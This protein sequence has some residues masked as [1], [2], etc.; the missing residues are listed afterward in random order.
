MKSHRVFE[1]RE[2]KKEKI[3][4]SLLSTFTRGKKERK[5][6]KEINTEKKREKEIRKE[7]RE[8]ERE[9][10]DNK[11]DK[12]L[13]YRSPYVLYRTKREGKRAE[14]VEEEE[15]QLNVDGPSRPPPPSL[16]IETDVWKKD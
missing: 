16:S 13:G 1:G 4:S 2:G 6:K 7:E 11:Q 5:S 8:R 14:E 10:R 3:L 12:T 9:A 15:E